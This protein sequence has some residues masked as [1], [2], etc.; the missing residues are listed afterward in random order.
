MAVPDVYTLDGK[1]VGKFVDFR[2][3]S[4]GRLNLLVRKLRV[5]PGT[6]RVFK[7]QWDA[8]RYLR[9]LYNRARADPKRYKPFLA[10]LEDEGYEFLPVDDPKSEVLISSDRVLVFQRDSR[11]LPLPI[12]SL[13]EQ[14]PSQRE[15]LAELY[16]LYMAYLRY[17]RPKL[18]EGWRIAQQALEYDRRLINTLMYENDRLMR[19]ASDLAEVLNNAYR[20]IADLTAA[21]EFFH[22]LYETYKKQSELKDDVIEKL[23]SYI[24]ITL[25]LVDK[26][27]EEFSKALDL[28]AEMTV[29]EWAGKQAVIEAVERFRKQL[30]EI[31]QQVQKFQSPPSVATALRG[32][33]EKGGGKGGEVGE[34]EAGGKPEE[35]S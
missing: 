34:K 5:L 2:P 13:L 24:P 7:K 17:E 26:I 22:R 35:K 23:M 10:L 29:S 6:A 33:V 30:A 11:W 25:E 9:H 19:T 32:E 1:W 8:I 21:M 28:S 20:R 14:S 12:Q 31:S 16:S 4:D 27:R 3:G 15:V 18:Y